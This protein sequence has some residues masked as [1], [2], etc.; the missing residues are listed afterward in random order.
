MGK[1]GAVM[2]VFDYIK[3]SDKA[4][5]IQQIHEFARI[6]LFCNFAAQ[7]R[8][9]EPIFFCNVRAKLESEK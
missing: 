4:E 1:R 6:C 2:K 9:G 5:V 7:C 8:M 3:E